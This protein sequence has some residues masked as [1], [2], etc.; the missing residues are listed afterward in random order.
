[1]AIASSAS[2]T[3]GRPKIGLG[4]D[5]DGADAEHLGRADD[6]AGDFAPVGNEKAFHHRRLTS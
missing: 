2:L 1:M 4:I 6:A 5:G 3:K